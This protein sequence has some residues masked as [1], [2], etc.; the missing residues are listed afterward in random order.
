MCAPP[1][2]PTPRAQVFIHIFTKNNKKKSDPSTKRD[3]YEDMKLSLLLFIGLV[4]NEL[5]LNESTTSKAF[6]ITELSGIT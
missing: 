1:G 3:T 6:R 4:Y 5:K 2:A